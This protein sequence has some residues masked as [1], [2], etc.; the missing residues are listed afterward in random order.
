LSQPTPGRF[1]QASIAR[2]A[3][4]GIAGLLLLVSI[5]LAGIAYLTV[6]A[7]AGREARAQLG[8]SVTAVGDIIDDGLRPLVRE[9]GTIA[10]DPALRD[11]L[12]APEAPRRLAAEKLLAARAALPGVLAVELRDTRGAPVLAAGAASAK[13]AILPLPLPRTSATHRPGR[14]FLAPLRALEGRV[15]VAVVAPVS[16]AGRRTG[17]LVHWLPLV[18]TIRLNGATYLLGNR[19]GSLWTD[20]T[21]VVP[22]PPVA[23]SQIVGRGTHVVRYARAGAPPRLAAV[24]AI[25]GAPWLGLVEM[26]AAGVL[27]PANRFL[28]RLVGIVLALF[29]VSLP[30]AWRWSHGL[31]RPL[32]QLTTAAEAIAAG[33]LDRRV[34]VD[35]RDEL[36]RLGA[37]FNDMADHVGESRRQLEETV[38]ELRRTHDQFTHAQRLQAVGR[39]AGGVAHDFNNLLTIILGEADLALETLAPNDPTR[40]ALAEI[41]AAARRATHLTSQLLAFSRKQ[42]VAPTLFDLNALLRD[43]RSMLRR[44]IG[45]HLQ[46]GV[47]TTDE[48]LPVLADHGQIEQVIVNLVVNARDAMPGGGRIHLET[49]SVHLDEA[50]AGA[51][52]EVTP[53]DYVVLIVSDTGHGMSDEVKA[54]LF[55]PFFTT[56][57]PGKGT[58][59]GLAACYGIVKQRGGHLAVYSE[60]GVGTTVKIFLP[61]AEMALAAPAAQRLEVPRGSETILLVED[62]PAVREVA[63][64]MLGALGYRVVAAP[65]AEAALSQ[66][67]TGDALD[68]LI[69]DV[70]L[71]RMSGREL[72]ERAAAL[73]PGLKVLFISGYTDDMALQHRL[74]DSD[75]ALLQKPFTAAGLG[76]RVRELLAG[77]PAA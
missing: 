19:D 18:L 15:V 27:E 3:L 4:V 63:S 42:L 64:R 40:T 57:E 24:A 51:R 12:A 5:T 70:V 39:L 46:I 23:V 45:E 43:T 53:G 56:K 52:E 74:I 65:D 7:A 8:S 77:A 26:P 44:L 69:T 11:F 41:H 50:Y 13:T 22:A 16:S 68:L 32:T 62:E 60:E 6:R 72:A 61:R 73:R 29:A 49:E 58:G 54:H 71:P 10:A 76:L 67:T 14:P 59:L 1:R 66:L 31:T 9:A 38:A 21:R 28:R 2:K 17:W 48:P 55:E 35:R 20:L 34:A 25:P 30:L 33:D 36:G 37:A 47:R 75:A